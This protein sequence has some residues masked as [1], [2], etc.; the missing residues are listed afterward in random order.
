MASTS[1][2][3]TSLRSK[4]KENTEARKPI[5]VQAYEYTMN[6]NG[7]RPLGEIDCSPGCLSFHL[8]A[9]GLTA[10]LWRRLDHALSLVTLGR[11]ASK[12]V[13]FL[14]LH[15]KFSLSAGASVEGPNSVTMGRL[16]LRYSF[17]AS[18]HSLVMVCGAGLANK[19]LAMN[20][21]AATPTETD[22]HR[23]TLRPSPGGSRARGPCGPK[24]IQ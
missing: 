8:T 20:I 7:P 16:T 21:K 10:A 3:L 22:T 6:G 4:E 15:G 23:A 14:A 13:G 11:Y 9:P 17:E 18:C 2:T 19:R 12:G 5:S 1:G 24:A